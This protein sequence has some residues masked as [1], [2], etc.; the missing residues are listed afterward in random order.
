[1]MARQVERNLFCQFSFNTSQFFIQSR[2]LAQQFLPPLVQALV[3]LPCPVTPP[4]D[5]LGPA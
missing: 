1:M 3:P 2:P 4:R 5:Q